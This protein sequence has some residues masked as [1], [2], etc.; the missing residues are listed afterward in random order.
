MEAIVAGT[1]IECN[2]ETTIIGKKHILVRQKPKL[3]I[4]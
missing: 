2:L 3:L 4:I 1:G